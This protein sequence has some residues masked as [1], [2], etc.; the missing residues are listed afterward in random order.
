MAC[1]PKFEGA[2]GLATLCTGI[3][4][5]LGEVSP[6]KALPYHRGAGLT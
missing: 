6:H 1:R 5:Q 4:A 2:L 3:D